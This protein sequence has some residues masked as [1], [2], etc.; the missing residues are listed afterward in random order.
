[1]FLS[2]RLGADASWDTLSY[3]LYT[4]YLLV[5]HRWTRDIMAIGVEQFFNPI[6]DLPFY[7]ALIV[8]RLPAIWIGLATAAVQGAG[9]WCVF[10][11]VT[12]I[13]PEDDGY[14]GTVAGI[15]AAVVATFGATYYMEIGAHMNDST[16]SGVVVAALVVV[17]AGIGDDG[18]I[19]VWSIAMAGML[20]GAA[21]GAKLVL[22]TSVAGFVA[23]IAISP[24]PLRQ[25]LRRLMA[26]GMAF[27]A[28]FLV[29]DGYWMWLMYRH[30]GHAFFPF[31]DPAGHSAMARVVAG[32]AL[33]YK[34]R[35]LAQW[36]FYPFYLASE[37]HLASETPIRDARFA[38]AYVAG[39]AFVSVALARWRRAVV[40]T[41]SD[42]RIVAVIAFA[43]G[44]YLLWEVRS[45]YYRYAVLIEMLSGVVVVAAIAFI[46]RRSL[47]VLAL[48]A[49]VCVFLVWS[50]RPT[51]AGRLPWTPSYFG[52]DSKYLEGYRDATILIVDRPIGYVMPYF[53]TS[54]SFVRVAKNLYLDGPDTREAI[55][56]RL[57]SVD[58]RRVYLLD[59]TPGQNVKTKA[60]EMDKLGVF[61]D[62]S[63]CQPF[64]TFIDSG[65]ICLVRFLEK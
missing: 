54:T 31:V 33:A 17:V 28:G 39:V 57:Q 55:D 46:A 3:H 12:L 13:W 9:I 49:P 37:Q 21:V 63:Q 4:P 64:S 5:D 38:A 24:G 16:L 26:F 15:A 40:W 45:S 36:L 30:R 29:V 27:L 62:Q 61:V 41:R 8:W 22:A 58:R 1:M 19:A 6:A 11:L 20:D 56:R 52:V 44:A 23:M 14:A 42:R 2:W 59:V 32:D 35:N 43:A 25:R 50:T 53:P 48:V 51:D 47:R 65:R 7:F 18:G 60:L 10:K 34:P